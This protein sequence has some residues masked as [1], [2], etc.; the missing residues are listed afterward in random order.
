MVAL[1]KRPVVW[2]RLE[3]IQRLIVL[4]AERTAHR[5]ED[6]PAQTHLKYLRA[7]G[8]MFSANYYADSISFTSTSPLD[9]RMAARQGPALRAPRAQPPD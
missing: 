2:E 3:R 9:E 4:A 5:G 1:L 6:A 7:V 8:A